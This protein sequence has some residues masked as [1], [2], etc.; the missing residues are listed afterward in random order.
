VPE[1]PRDVSSLAQCV[2]YRE[3][4]YCGNELIPKHS[5]AKYNKYRMLG[6]RL[7]LLQIAECRLGSG[8]KA[9]G[10]KAG[11]ISNIN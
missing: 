3:T 1:L 5:S 4:C 6:S 10:N 11:C 2:R 8:G 7:V 9:I